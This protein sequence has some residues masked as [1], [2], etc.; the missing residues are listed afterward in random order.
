MK[1]TIFLIL[2]LAS[3][4]FAQ[5]TFDLKNASKFFDVKV[6]VEKCDDNSCTGKASFSF[7]KKGGVKAYQVINLPDTYVQLGDGG[8][9]LVN[10]TLL[11][12]DQS[13]IVVD[14]FNF[15]GMEDVAICDGTNGGYG[16]P[17]YQ[18][19]LSSRAA[20]KFVRSPAFT[21]LGSHLGMFEV[22]KESKTLQIMDKSGCCW[23]E[24]TRYK[25]IGGRPVKVWVLTEDAQK[26]DEKANK[27]IVVT[28]EKTLVKGRWKTHV[29]TERVKDDN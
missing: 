12:D 22:D 10:T 18:I 11:Y 23:H 3:A 1:N 24:S 21:D 17:S 25:V 26:F 5:H 6:N 4:T 27:R 20:G 19:Y 29:T 2:L 13:V 7:Y 16:M 8:K 15:D 9:P 14:D 28:T